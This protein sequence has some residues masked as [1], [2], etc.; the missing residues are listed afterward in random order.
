MSKLR[1]KGKLL[2]LSLVPLLLV[3]AA[4]MIIVRVQ[5]QAMGDE[6]VE[7]IRKDMLATKQTE[8]RHYVEQAISAV[9]PLL[10]RKGITD[11][12]KMERVTEVLNAMRFGTDGYIF[13]F[14]PQ[15]VTK[16]HGTNPSLIGKDLS[17]L[18]DPNGVLFTQE[19][20]KAG[21]SGGGFVEY[22]WEKPQLGRDAPKLSYAQALPGK[23]WVVGT[24]FYIDDIDAA[25]AQLENQIR[26]SIA[27]TL[28][29]IGISALILLVL[30]SLVTLYVAQRMVRPLQQTAAAL[31]DISR[32]EGD[33]TQR[34]P[35]E[36]DD[37][38]GDVAR[39][40]NDFVEKIQ[41]LVRE[42]Q[43]AVRSLSQSTESMKHVVSQ[44]HEDAHKQKGET[45]QAA[46]AI[47][48]MAAAVQQVAGSAAQAADAAR[49]A[50][51]ESVNGQKVVEHTIESINRLADDVNRSA[52]VIASL[53]T[54][55]DQI[56]TVI[57]VISSIAE[58]TNLLA[59]NAAIEAARA[60][61]QG[62]G[63][64]VVADEVRTLATRTQQST[65][66]I[67]RM[68]ERLQS[69]A[70][71]A[72]TEMQSS[73]AQSQD[74][75]ERADEA[76]NS[77]QQIT[78]SVSTITEMNTQI[79]S[80]AEEQ[81]A[82]ADEISKSV[83]QIADIADKATHNAEELAGTASQMGELETRLNQLVS[84]FKA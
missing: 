74:T 17:G 46:A 22:S 31:K 43:T 19:L 70:R 81:T 75:I 33:L 27:T 54:D 23:D 41:Q 58:Q 66:E 67:Q 18:K 51:G 12:E 83:Q 71:N 10:A 7:R 52:E 56:G 73:Q 20:V 49:E 80:A 1:L 30:V 25:V 24:G 39:G 26:S 84:R 65:D 53:G 79:A 60:G 57:N 34:L 62:R 37:E 68:I 69:G 55:A 63:F 15:G 29:I 44:T 64:S 50:D 47:H 9:Q 2:L 21:R 11:D 36:T 35:V 13:A 38:V 59:L 61:E 82:V 48:Q 3:V 40:F 32:G 45:S 72:V 6:E 16:V 5:M 14:D 8:L 76:R 42:V 77:L 4:I 28:G 78:H